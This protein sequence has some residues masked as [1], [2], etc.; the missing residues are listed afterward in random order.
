MAR[1]M[2]D[3]AFRREQERG[4]YAAHVRPINE[5]VDSLR[6]HDGR[7]WLPHVAPW[8]GG[9]NAR[10][11][12]VLRD[13][14][15][16]T[17]DGTGSGFL[18]IENDDPTAERQAEAFA[19]VGVQPG[20]I[21]PW[22]AYPWYINRAPTS[23]ERQAGVDPLLRLLELLPRLQVVFLQGNDAKDTWHRVLGRDPTV[24]RT[25]RLTTIATYHP[26][27]QALWAR[28]PAIREMRT[29]HRIDAYQQLAAALRGQAQ[30]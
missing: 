13:P 5:F 17:Q 25:H 24:E 4:R 28:D 26:S 16:A 11:L 7:G 10:V 8:H 6:G 30:P 12:S 2:A 9:V 29:Q 22:N 3:E 19:A 20:D 1:R 27:R 15:P 14:G 21:T 23:R 18:C